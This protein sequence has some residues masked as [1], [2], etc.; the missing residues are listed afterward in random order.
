[1][2]DGFIR[3]RLN[4]EDISSMDIEEIEMLSDQRLRV[5]VCVLDE[6]GVLDE[7]FSKSRGIKVLYKNRVQVNKIIFKN[8]DFG[9]NRTHDLCFSAT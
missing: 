2:N 3:P 8:Y 6:L 5:Y 7:L 9:E 4:D 1:M